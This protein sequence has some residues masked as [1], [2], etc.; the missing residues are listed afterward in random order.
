MQEGEKHLQDSKQ[1][2]K[3]RK[4]PRD[5]KNSSPSCT[6]HLIYYNIGHAAP[7]SIGGNGLRLDIGIGH[8]RFL[9]LLYTF[10]HFIVIIIIYHGGWVFF[11]ERGVCVRGGNDKPR[12][13]CRSSEAKQLTETETG[14]KGGRVIQPD[15]VNG[16]YPMMHVVCHPSTARVM[17]QRK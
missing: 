15:R 8:G 12:A 11:K 17:T 16:A 14:T 13:S 9:V 10:L 4:R 2:Q 7:A 5:F 1:K 6:S 3:K